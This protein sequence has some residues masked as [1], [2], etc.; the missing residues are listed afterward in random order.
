MAK[1]Q[2]I[3]SATAQVEVMRAAAAAD[4][5]PPAHVE[6]QADDLPFFKSVIDEFA[7]SEWSAHQL[8]LAAFLARSMADFESEQLSLRNEG[9]VVR[10]N[11][12]TPVAN[13]RKAVVQMH[14]GTILSIRRSLSLHAR[15]QRGEARDVGGR[16]AAAQ[17]IEANNPLNDDLLGA[18]AAKH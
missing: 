8:E 1:R 17:A 12:G 13:P 4:V 16:R 3:D 14:A 2:R 9:S 11:K 6:L 7:R 5:S 10:T 15:A 18:P